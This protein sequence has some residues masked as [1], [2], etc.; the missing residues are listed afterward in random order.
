MFVV[1][2]WEDCHPTVYNDDDSIIT[3][4]HN[5]HFEILSICI[6]YRIILAMFSVAPPWPIIKRAEYLKYT[7]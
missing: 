3:S 2:G 6:P 4:H 5:Q 7:L 1:I